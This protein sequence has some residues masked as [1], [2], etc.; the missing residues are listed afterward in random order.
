MHEYIYIYNYIEVV[1]V[2]DHKVLV[3]GSSL[4]TVVVVVV[5]VVGTV[6]AALFAV[7]LCIESS[8]TSHFV[9]DTRRG[10]G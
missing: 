10:R 6:V 4:E 5:V 9:F 2:G 8:V 7:T 3:A 1:A